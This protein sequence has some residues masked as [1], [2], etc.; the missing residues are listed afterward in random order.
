VR[1][2]LVRH[3]ESICAV[4]G[5]VGG[6]KGCTG[7]TERG[8][9]QAQA[10][11][12]RFE[13][14]GFVPDVVLASTLPRGRQTAETLGFP[15]EAS[16]DLVELIPGVI[17]GTPWADFAG[18]D[19]QTEPDRPVS[20]GGE[21]L[22]VFK[23]RVRGLIERLAH[24]HDGRT[25]VAVCHGGVIG[26]SLYYGLRAPDGSLSIDIDFTSITEWRRSDDGWVLVRCND[27]AHLMGT[28][29]LARV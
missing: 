25:V 15:F 8:F 20:E 1:L 6:A 26:A 10:L 4:N 11:R 22:N 29:L 14:E 24:E 3:G 19:I 7:L 23:V 5:I 12:D 2:V 28:D 27:H 17:D 21:S 9:A 16:D 18:F 13:R